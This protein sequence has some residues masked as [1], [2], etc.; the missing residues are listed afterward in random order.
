MPVS[1]VPSSIR[2]LHNLLKVVLK[3]PVAVAFSSPAIVRRLLASPEPN[4]NG[5]MGPE[6]YSGTPLL[7]VD[8]VGKPFQCRTWDSG[9]LGAQMLGRLY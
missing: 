6:R 9:Y 1:Q 3:L 5:V 8:V 4:Q 2:E 7:L